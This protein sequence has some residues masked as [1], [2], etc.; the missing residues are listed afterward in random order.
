MNERQHYKNTALNSILLIFIIFL[1]LK[2]EEKIN[3][4]M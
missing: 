2:E 4:Q 1:I 3:S